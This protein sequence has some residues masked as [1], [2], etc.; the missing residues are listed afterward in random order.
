MTDVFSRLRENRSSGAAV[1]ACSVCSSHPLV[2][3]AAV[4][5]AG[6][7]GKP[8]LVEATANQVNQHGGYTGLVPDAF[9]ALVNRLCREND[10]DQELVVLGGDHL[11]PYPWRAMPVALAMPEAERLVREFVRAGAGKIHLDASMPLAD[12]AGGA[13]DRAAAA[14]RAVRLCRAAEEESRLRQRVPPVY[15]IGTEVPV[16]G[17]EAIAGTAGAAPAPTRPEDFRDTVV[18][19]KQLFHEAGLDDAWSRVIAVVVQPGIDFDALTI[20]PYRHDPAAGL[21]GALAD[22]PGLVFE[23]HS[24]DYQSTG[25]LRALVEDGFAI[26]KVGPELTFALREA[27]FGLEAIEGALSGGKAGA[28]R[29]SATVFEAMQEK[30][31][32]W[33]GYYPE[34][35]RLAFC[36]TYGYSDRMR[37]YW[38]EP[39]VASAVRKLL[40]GLD[41]VAIPPQLISQFI[42]H[43]G[44][45]EDL[46]PAARSPKELLL[47]AVQARLLRY[48]RACTPESSRKTE[49]LA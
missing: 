17:G 41:R 7:T 16:P 43:I 19:H 22:A 26:L 29:L 21:V 28:S 14:V 47:R 40:G 18:L 46:P 34:G 6:R 44:P 38:N 36:M 13:L 11:G 12:D 42:P 48:V 8:F 35:D 33:K 24:T 4:R 23:G 25:A 37:Y 45:V 20:H 39:R 2:I 32:S 3:E 15:V 1:G 5:L 10:V 49:V 30:P 9:I 31:Q 27:L